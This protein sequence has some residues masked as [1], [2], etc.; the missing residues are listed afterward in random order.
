MFAE[1][2]FLYEEPAADCAAPSHVSSPRGSS[3][4]KPQGVIRTAIVAVIILGC[5]LP[6]LASADNDAGQWTSLS[7]TIV[8]SKR[9][10]TSFYAEERFELSDP[11]VQ[12]YFTGFILRAALHP[13][14][15]IGAGF[16]YIRNRN[17]DG[18]YDDLGRVEAEIT[19][20]MKPRESLT[21]SLRNRIEVIDGSDREAVVRFRHRLDFNWR[22][23]TQTLKALF[24]SG[25][26][27]YKLT[28]GTPTYD[29]LRLVP[30]GLKVRVTDD[31]SVKLFYLLQLKRG[32]LNAHVLG[33]GFSFGF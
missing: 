10:S 30:F 8:K 2:T 1:N 15:G 21:T 18:G 14:L 19:P 25:E 5:G 22:I 9:V 16:K 17:S 33:T 11:G 29:Q 24:V 6:T 32:G 20:R 4:P 27:F 26:L 31:A 3:C 13:N 23:P 12:G 28:D 7:L